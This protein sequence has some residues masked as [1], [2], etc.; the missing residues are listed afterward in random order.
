MTSN[1]K[2]PSETDRYVKQ[3]MKSRIRE[4]GLTQRD[5]AARLSITQPSVANVLSN[6]GAFIPGSL[7]RLLEVLDLELIVEVRARESIDI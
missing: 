7:L 3:A 2:V 5:L 6:R 1:R 4:L